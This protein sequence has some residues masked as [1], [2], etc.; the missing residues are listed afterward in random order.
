MDRRALLRLIG[1]APVGAPMMLAAASTSPR[2]MTATL[3]VSIPGAEIFSEIQS[4][5]RTLVQGQGG[6]TG[7]AR[8]VLALG[9]HAWELPGFGQEETEE[10][11]NGADSVEMMEA[12]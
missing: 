10:P 12:A 2:V 1:V 9:Q 5:L 7:L 3:G 6:E 4:E 11:P 8:D